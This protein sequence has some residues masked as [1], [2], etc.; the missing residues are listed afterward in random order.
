MRGGE[1]VCVFMQTP[2]G[3]SHIRLVTAA[4]LSAMFLDRPLTATDGDTLGVPRYTTTA[5]SPLPPTLSSSRVHN[6]S[7][8]HHFLLGF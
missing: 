6:H 5:L 4:V 7:L 8:S 3:T 1:F 2:G